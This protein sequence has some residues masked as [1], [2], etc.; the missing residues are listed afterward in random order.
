MSRISTTGIL[1]CAITASFASVSCFAT[2]LH[3]ANKDLSVLP[4]PETMLF[5]IA[6]AI[7]GTVAIVA[8]RLVMLRFSQGG[9]VSISIVHVCLV[10]AVMINAAIILICLM[11]A[12]RG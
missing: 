6:A 5:E 4:P 9:R 11:A 2:A 8:Y 3:F 7:S 1:L 10:M 12:T